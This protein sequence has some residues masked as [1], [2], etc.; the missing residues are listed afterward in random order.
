MPATS[1]RPG[2]GLRGR[3]ARR[4]DCSTFLAICIVREQ[5][6]CTC[7]MATSK[8]D[9]KLITLAEASKRFGLSPE[10]LR[11]IARSGRLTAQKIGRDWLT[12]PADVKAYIASRKKKGAYR[13]D[14][15]FDL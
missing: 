11:A 6:V 15:E 8:T 12:T 4:Q 7:R 9:R 14:L 5:S 3:S 1:Q 10:Y 2:S 13:D